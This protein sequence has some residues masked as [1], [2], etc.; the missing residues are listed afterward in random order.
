MRT[1]RIHAGRHGLYAI[2]VSLA[3]AVG[4]GPAA[5][6]EDPTNTGPNLVLG[7]APVAGHYY[8][9]GGALCRLINAHRAEDGLRCLVE[10]T[11]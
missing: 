5:A 2:L 11:A 8:P 9:T 3:A 10:A 6:Q 1:P 4:I 7:T